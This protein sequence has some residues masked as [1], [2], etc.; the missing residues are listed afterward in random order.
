[1]K[2][3][4][5]TVALCSVIYSM[6]NPAYSAVTL[7]KE[8]EKVGISLLQGALQAL[9]QQRIALLESHDALAMVP[10]IRDSF[11][12]LKVLK[13]S[14]TASPEQIASLEREL[15]ILAQQYIKELDQKTI[16]SLKQLAQQIQDL[17][18]KLRALGILPV[19]EDTTG[20][21]E[22]FSL[23]LI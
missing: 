22:I 4:I 8:H 15:G 5:L 1:M 9:N 10:R 23:I 14:L 16:Q 7:E 2:K 18:G 19:L 6:H 17:K 11:N 21:N 20:Q 3:K 12:K 13:E